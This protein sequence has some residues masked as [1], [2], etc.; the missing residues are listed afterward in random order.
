MLRRLNE[1][2]FRC[3]GLPVSIISRIPHVSTASDLQPGFRA[4]LRC[5]GRPRQSET[6]NQ[7]PRTELPLTVYTPD[8]G[9]ADP[10]RL[11]R[12]MAAELRDS[13]E[14]AYTLFS[15]DMKAQF[16]QSVLGYAWLF[17]LRLSPPSSG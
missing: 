4:Q 2:S 12:E 8:S 13:R 11:S 14:L 1:K 9:L 17:Y 5:S 6:K 10:R 3:P 16:R 15:R 7:E